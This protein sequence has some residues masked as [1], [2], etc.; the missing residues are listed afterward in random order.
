MS[1]TLTLTDRARTEL[2]DGTARGVRAVTFTR[3]AIGSGTTPAGTDDSARTTLRVQ[4]DVVAVTGDTA[5]T[6]QIAIRGD[7]SAIAETFAV[8]EVGLFARTG[9][10][11]EWL[12]G[13]WCGASGSDAIARADPAATLVVA[14]SVVIAASA[15]EVAVTV[16]ATIQVGPVAAATTGGRGLIE[17]ATVAE[18][19][20]GADTE[21][22]VT[23]AGVADVMPAGAIIDFA[24]PR[25]PPGWLLCDGR[26]VSRTTYARLWAAIIDWWGAGDGSTTFNLPDLRRHVRMGSGGQASS[27][28]GTTVGWR[29]G[30]E[31]HTLTAA[32]MPAHTHGDGT[33]SASSA[34]SHTHGRGTLAASRAAAH[35]H[36][37]GTLSASSAGAHTHGDGT[38][39]AASA[40]EHTH[41][42]SHALGLRGGG[43]RSGARGPIDYTSQ[44]PTAASAGSHSHDVTG[45]TAAGGS[46]T[47]GVAGAT[48]S[49]GAHT[50]SVT[51]ATSSAGAHTHSVTGRTGSV[52]GGA[53]HSILQPS[54]IVHSIIRY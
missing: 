53:A 46:H 47:H 39:R 5:V 41:A 50:H 27:V 24:G 13:Y 1:V 42:V 35:T 31:T 17:L 33:L 44:P 14:G 2:A 10:G 43:G 23:P 15:A 20:A 26:A 28:I 29:A 3:L 51:G 40:G 32:E 16:A 36:G 12:A 4:K 22:A 34:G 6:G 7:F 9:A 25:V 11:A 21:R 37:D 19:R 45:R 30:A 8:T 52:G 49:S 38:L 48:S 54:A 18:V